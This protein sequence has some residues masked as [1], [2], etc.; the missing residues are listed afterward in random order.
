MQIDIDEAKIKE[1]VDAAVK[2]KIDE[3]TDEA[4]CEKVQE[5]L[6]DRID[7][8]FSRRDAAINYYINKNIREII[9]EHTEINSEQFDEAVKNI[10]N[11]IALSLQKQIVESIANNLISEEEAENY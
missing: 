9:K 3:L 11:E 4:I 10:A 5:A 8:I 6:F 7:S 1:Y 2:Q